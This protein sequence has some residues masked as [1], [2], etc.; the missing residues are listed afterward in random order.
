MAS[1][2]TG[3]A[4]SVVWTSAGGGISPS[5]T[6]GGSPSTGVASAGGGTASA[7]PSAGGCSPSAGG[8]AASA[9][10]SPKLFRSDN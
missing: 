8:A 7:A 2:S 9:G 4:A 3:G 5:G 1:P 6:V 10:A